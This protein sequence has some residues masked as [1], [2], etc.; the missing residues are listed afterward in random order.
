MEMRKLT[1]KNY[2]EL[3]ELLNFT[4]ATKYGRAMDFLCEQ[5]KMWVRDDEHMQKHIGIFEGGKLAAVVGIYPLPAIIDG[6]PVLFAT[7]GNVAT[8]PEFEGRGYFT[9]IFTEI[10]REL[11]V[12]DAD[13]ARLGGARQ[14]YGRFGF[15]PCGLLHKF[16]INETNYKKCYGKAPDVTFRPVE[17]G[18]TKALKFI[19][20]LSE[21]SLM[22][23]K[24]C[25]TDGY[26]DVHLALS[27]K[28]A[29]PYIAERGGEP[30]GYLSAYGDNQ[31]VGFSDYGK[32]IAEIRANTAE[33]FYSMAMCW[34]AT[35]GTPIDVPV[36]PFMIGEL[37]ILSKVAESHTMGS[38]SHFRFRKFENAADALMRVKAK[39]SD[40]PEG[41]FALEIADY[42]KICFYN[43]GG[44]AG[45]EK[46]N[47]ATSIILNKN[48]AERVI[49]GTLPTEAICDL[50][51]I[52]R[53]FLP[54][55][56]T[57]NTNDYT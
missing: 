4:F 37:R 32:H 51:W 26:R 42:G 57:W 11:D 40:I 55:P 43:R 5:P 53:A 45:C 36:S 38:P 28:H 2:D 22:Y 12:I 35:V 39:T 17:L 27:S 6:T 30:I 29:R 15:E 46:T 7:T 31:F 3:L 48:E 16:T 34:Q 25:D 14:R 19:K 47:I 21:R 1:A 54:L 13:A 44:K 50:P 18:D 9:K 49:F 10:M 20:E 8:L 23:I 52:A 24:R 56:L 33:D 41:E